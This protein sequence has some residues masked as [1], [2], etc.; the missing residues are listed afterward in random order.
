MGLDVELLPVV[1]PLEVVKLNFMDEFVLIF[2]PEFVGEAAFAVES[3]LV[4]ETVL[5]VELESVAEPVFVVE[6]ELVGEAA[7]VLSAVLAAGLTVVSGVDAVTTFPTLPEVPWIV[8]PCT[9]T[10]GTATV[11]TIWPPESNASTNS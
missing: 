3:E 9:V 5:V 10:G 11:V 7:F 2:E 8:A 4:G 6:L 1:E